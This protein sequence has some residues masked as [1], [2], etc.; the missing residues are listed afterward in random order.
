MNIIDVLNALEENQI[1]ILL[2]GD[3]LEINFSQETIPD[4]VIA[5]L[6]EYKPLLVNYLKEIEGLNSFQGIPIA[7][8]DTSYPLSSSQM[9]LWLLSQ[10]DE[11]S[12]VYHLPFSFKIQGDYDFSILEQSIYALIKR[13]ESLRTV[14]KEDVEG[15]VRQ[16]IIPFEALNFKVGFQDLT[17]TVAAQQQ[18]EDYIR[19]D[20]NTPFDLENG[21]LLRVTFF[22][23]GA[24]DYVCYYNMHH[25]ISDG[26]SMNILI[27]DIIAFYRTFS[28]GVGSA[29]SSLRIQY[30][31]YAV[32]QNE[33][34]HSGAYEAHRVYWMNKFAG[35]L[36]SLNLPSKFQ[37]PAIRTYNGR[38]LGIY[39]DKADS[40]LI[41]NYVKAHGGSL[42]MFLVASIKV[43]FHRNTAEED[44]ILGSPVAGRDH[45]DL[46]EQIGCYINTL[47]IRST[48]DGA[49]TFDAFYD[50]F[51][52]DLL[53]SYSHQVYPFDRLVND[54]G[55]GRDASRSPLF[56]VMVALQNT[57]NYDNADRV[58]E[59]YLGGK[60]HD[61]PAKA[62]FDMEFTFVE[63]GDQIGMGL[64]YNTDVYDY[65]SIT[66]LIRQYQRLVQIIAADGTKAIESYN[67][68]SEEERDVI[69]NVFNNTR[70]DYPQNLTVVDLF[71]EQARLTPD[72]I[73]VSFESTQLTY[74]ELDEITNQLADCLLQQYEV[75][76]NDLIAIK[77]E[78]SHWMLISIWGILKS[79]GAY[80]PIDPS[81]P[82]DRIE[83]V[84]QDSQCKLCI[85]EAFLEQFKKQKENHRKEPIP[86]KTKGE[87]L[88]YA[89][90][91]SGSTG[92][93]KGVINR[94]DGLY[95]R[96]LWMRNDLDIS[97]K[98]IIL[99]KTPYMFDVS[100]WELTMLCCTGS[101]VVFAKP[102]GHKEPRYLQELIQSAQISILHFVP[103]ML[104]V[105]LDDLDPDTC[106]SLR[107]VVC[108]G[109]ALPND[110]VLNF[111][112]LLPWVRIHN[113][114]GPTE[115][116]ID[117]TSID[118][119][120]VDTRQNGVTIGKSV[121]N[122]RIY[123][124]DKNFAL[125]PIGVPG[126]LLIEGVQ[127]ANGYLN[128]PEL[129][130][131]KFIESP[132]NKGDRIYRTGDLAKWLPNGEIV[133]IGRIDNQVKLR[134]N[135][136]ELGEIEQVLKAYS[137]AIAQVVVAVVERNGHQSLVAYYTQKEAVDK[138]AMRT[139]LE[140]KV[141]VYMV[142]GYFVEMESIPLTP[143]G[144]VDRKALI[145]H[146]FDRTNEQNYVAPTNKTEE[147]LVKIWEEILGLEK[148]GIR[149][150]F[151]EIGGNS[152]LTQQVLNKI[153]KQLK[154][155]LTYREFFQAPVIE[156]IAKKLKLGAFSSIPKAEE[157]DGYP[158]TATQQQIWVLSQ[159]KGGSEA[160]NIPGIARLEGQLDLE[161]LQ[162]AYRFLI[163]RHEILRTSFN[164]DD[165]GKTRQYVHP[166]EA[167]SV[168]IIIKDLSGK[169]EKEVN[170]YLM[171]EFTTPFDLTTAP[172]IETLLVKTGEQSY[173]F[174]FNFHH[175][176][177]D[178]WS[179]ELLVKEFVTFYNTLIQGSE[180]EV[181]EL[182]LQFKD[183]AAWADAQIGR[184]AYL[185]SENYW[186]TKFA[187][188][189]P[190]L[191]LPSYK[192][193]PQFITYNGRT[194]RHRYPAGFVEKLEAFSLKQKVS[195]FMTLMAGIYTLIH[196]YTGQNDIILGTPIA[197]REHPDLEEQIGLYLNTLAIRANVENEDRFV[198]ILEKQKNSLLEAYEHQAYPFDK[199][200]NKVSVNRNPSRSPLFDATVVF[201]NHSKVRKIRTGEVLQNI[202]AFPY[203]VEGTT[204]QFDMSFVFEVSEILEMSIEFNTD[205]YDEEIIL[206]LFQHFETLMEDA[207]DKPEEKI[208]LLN[209]IS[210]TE[211]TQLVESFNQTEIN[212]P[213][214]CTIIELF[215]AQVNRAGPQTALITAE[216]RLSYDALNAKANQLG[217][218]LNTKYKVQPNDL[219]GI[220]LEKDEH[221]ITAILGVL[222][223]GAAYVP[224]DVD[225][226][227]S[228]I[229]YIETD[230][231]CKVVL[232][233]AEMAKFYQE[234]AKYETSNVARANQPEDL[235]YIIYTSGSTGKPKGVKVSHRNVL[236]L[237]SYQSKYFGISA[238]DTFLLFYSIS[239]DASVEQL[240]LALLNGCGLFIPRKDV[241]L[242]K[243]LLNAALIQHKITHLD[244]VPSFLRE[245]QEEAGMQIKRVVSGGELFNAK[246]LDNWGDQVD[247]Y[248]VYGPT[249]TTVTVTER[250]I[251]R[252][253]VQEGCIGKPIG[254]VQC[255]VL[256]SNQMLVPLGVRG[257]LC[258]GG[259]CVTQGYLNRP[260][261]T[262]ER[263]IS[264]PFKPGEQIY[265][266]GDLAKWLP[267]GSLEF[268]GRIDE[269]V[270][271]RG[272]RIELGEIEQAILAYQDTIEQAAVVV[273]Q[274]SG[275][276]W[277]VAYYTANET[278]SSNVLK[279]YLNE[280]LPAFM[281]PHQLISLDQMP[282]TPN[283]K[284]DRN[285]L[286][287]RSID[288][289]QVDLYMAPTNVVE[290]KMVQIWEDLLGQQGIGI[291][292]NFFHVG[293][294][295]LLIQQVLFRSNKQLDAGLTYNDFFQFP[296][297]RELGKIVE[298]QSPQPT[299]TN[300]MQEVF[301]LKKGQQPDKHIFF[302]H[303]GVG[304][305][306]GYSDL[307]GQLETYHCWGVKSDLFNQ[308]TPHNIGLEQL[309][310]NYV[311]QIL[312]VQ[313]EGPYALVGWSSGGLIAF[314]MMKELE[315]RKKNIAS[316]VMIDSELPKKSG[317]DHIAEFS[318]ESELAMLPK[319]FP[320][321]ANLRGKVSSLSEL[322]SVL[323][324][325][326]ENNRA[327]M[328]LLHEYVM[329]ERDPGKS[330]FQSMTTREKIIYVNAIRTIRRMIANYTPEPSKCAWVYIKAKE[331]TFNFPEL[332]SYSLEAVQLI[333]L[334]GDHYSIMQTPQV[335]QM[336]DVIQAASFHGQ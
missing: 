146:N 247:I 143:N 98:D 71:Y 259:A 20:N 69:L 206:R 100:V 273:N 191:E 103:S 85:D 230:S 208:G 68:L 271:I 30:K 285:T 312:E 22:K 297:I 270:K 207:M 109:E 213:Q 14:F 319:L 153:Y 167:L 205:I 162:E 168:E 179:M 227:A 289:K 61:R 40:A 52:K 86:V 256:D 79:G 304:S 310:A 148:V 275:I 72:R 220:K 33:Q 19:K 41:R 115:A 128:R 25:I 330:N 5:L 218:Y 141:P 320:E 181:P 92:K 261:L 48:L 173:I 272:Y 156:E 241:L 246:I 8:P 9:R 152:V 27:R 57:E 276:P 39:L 147:E 172:L 54:L 1:S 222:K 140:E 229:R 313:K 117:V 268:C 199:L 215:E 64:N 306:D 58:S 38:L 258:I 250:K 262:A 238:A 77:L 204:S 121:A 302:I 284:I 136:I 237:I 169:S 274:M 102:E 154:G 142:P 244:A 216:N 280:E 84:E 292:D 324:S 62:K 49:M 11:V 113:L 124:V 174:T 203:E 159:L 291:S 315:N 13:H 97:Q 144:K 122:T 74:R 212:Y 253:N 125:Q 126:E 242:N 76:A 63:V 134:G 298:Q 42:F 55:L 37:R 317:N 96:L 192:K 94:H 155:T 188:E 279:D 327:M 286:E 45:T 161:K 32:W 296:T 166:I 2:D 119:T 201:L 211:T 189:M 104:R 321:L 91:T 149:D 311:D 59:I 75:K 200:V 325:Q 248:N 87:H 332:K 225:Y 249:E 81:Y 95:N 326:T 112:E 110:I 318:L 219:I 267:D 252:S 133:Y 114:Y 108:S 277:L 24:T 170:Q 151:F 138:E 307:I 265:R 150:N 31:D 44:I 29:L 65:E 160:Y 83:F 329:D 47:A 266:T 66:N 118:L 334:E 183:Y 290:E 233:Q 243:E 185:A 157:Q 186:L 99:Q 51:K 305:V 93:P 239:F 226:P 335:H 295:S 90:Y 6:R 224:I 316:F 303:D 82:P 184:E 194:I 111:K 269:Q 73:A 70:I 165:L 228:R 300:A 171:D 260:E 221:L 163:R 158:L 195:L 288:L 120:E 257:E 23:L 123:I 202:E 223:S 333:E 88:A 309:A 131:E 132:F 299:K 322:W 21:P 130:A 308:I 129:N 135:R 178:G 43:L 314:Q 245:I 139:F 137:A 197:G 15:Q 301:L 294:N 177:G 331:S 67:Y 282:L 254:N 193:R 278:I 78:R 12:V 209:Y 26:W 232:D 175:L 336:V 16:W 106:R 180:I 287:N 18:I 35:N 235:A 210:A 231:Q 283:G 145:A 80:V 176:I 10:M 7:Q 198:D 196:R 236:N 264:N 217:R 50:R 293:G 89:I 182:P 251:D 4:E 234:Q 164:T 107:H 53:E 214:H 46:E 3:D 28:E 281:V 190:V 36:P 105:F 116:A 56:D 187:G 34:F 263:F 328:D 60:D 127:V 323:M 240:F 17:N 101:Q 255:Y